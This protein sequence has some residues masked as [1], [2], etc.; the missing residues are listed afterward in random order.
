MPPAI[1]RLGAVHVALAGTPEQVHVALPAKPAPGLTCR[2]KV[3]VC[4]AEIVAE[5]PP[6]E[7]GATVKAGLTLAEMAIVCGELGA[8]S[9]IVTVAVRRPK[10]MGAT[11]M[12]MV[13]V[14]FTA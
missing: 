10:E 3:A 2:E 13:Q 14:A 1:C 5:L 12:P 8:S 4:P 7:L 6:A 9:A 11:L